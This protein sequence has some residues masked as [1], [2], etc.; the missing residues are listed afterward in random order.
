MIISARPK[1][2][3]PAGWNAILPAQD[4]PVEL[5]DAQTADWLVIGA[6][7]AGLTAARRLS[8]LRPEDQIVVLDAGRVAHG[9]AGRNS[10][11]M[12]DLPHDLASDNYSGAPDDDRATT[13]D[14]R[15]AIDFAENFTCEAGLDTEAFAR[16]GKINGAASAR[17]HKANE[18]FAAHLSA[19]G[20]PF[21]MLDAKQMQ[22]MTGGS[23]Y[24][25]GLYTPGA[26]II[27]PAQYI[28]ALGANLRT[29]RVSI[30]ENSPVLELSRDGAWVASTPRGKISA[31]RVILAVNGHLQS[32]GHMTGRLAH[33]FTYASMTRA[34][35]KDEIARL[36]GTNRWGLTPA[37]PMGSSVR[38]ISGIG[39]DRLLVRN[40]FTFEPTMEVS[41][42]KV[43]RIGH[44]HDRSFAARFPQLSD[45]E[46]EYRWGGRLCLAL[47]NVQ[48]IGELDDGL[49][50]ACCQ[51][52][53]GTVRGTLAGLLAA[54][55][56]C[57][58]T[59]EALTRALADKP[60]KRLPPGPIALIGARLKIGWMEKRAGKEL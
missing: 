39:G 37:D 33:V 19:L 10:G 40:R 32:F 14:N 36:G 18:E 3:G 11:F 4:A 20:E 38:R 25:G 13:A 59:S 60:P 55:A 56:A 1:D 29:N 42:A 58:V 5:E 35:T 2:P 23:F 34:L 41:D 26:A 7:F 6:G 49:W 9:P 17:G 30:F 50:S 47:N 48:V 28:R 27:Q 46:M 15:K 53:L 45:V 44:D 52:G 43:A 22:D 31:P 12:V 16:C 21:E 57:G 54:E 24:S 51:N 8:Q